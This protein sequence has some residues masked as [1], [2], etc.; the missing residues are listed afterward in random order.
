M[1]DRSRVVSEKFELNILLLTQICFKLDCHLCLWK[2]IIAQ[3]VSLYCTVPWNIPLQLKHR[4]TFQ[5]FCKDIS[6]NDTLQRFLFCYKTFSFVQMSARSNFILP[7]S[8][9]TH[10]SPAIM[11][12]HHEPQSTVALAYEMYLHTVAIQQYVRKLSKLIYALFAFMISCAIF[13]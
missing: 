1:N 3:S 5:M 11:S 12:V 10:I 8:H 7:W 4:R 9:V 6:V 2:S 13:F